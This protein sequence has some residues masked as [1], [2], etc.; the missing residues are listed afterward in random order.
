[1]FTHFISD[2]HFY[3]ANIV[4][5]CKRPFA[6]VEAM[7]DALVSNIR[8]HTDER[9]VVLW[10]G[11]VFFCDVDRAQAIMRELPGRHVLV[12]G[13]HDGTAS[14]MAR[15]GFSAVVDQLT[16]QLNDQTIVASHFPTTQ[17]PQDAVLMHG[18]TH[19]TERLSPCGKRLHVG[20]DAW[21]Y[22]PASIDEILALLSLEN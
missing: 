13:N 11:D 4:E 7:N 15:C 12:R 2:T 22:R 14:R 21:D 3:H 20:V 10:L 9:S 1:M 17:R 5:F 18:H 16:F 6:D 19:S 8:N